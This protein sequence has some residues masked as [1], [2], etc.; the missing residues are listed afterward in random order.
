MQPRMTELTAVD[1]FCGGGGL[2]VGLKQAGFRVVSAVE[3]EAH[4]FST[5]KANHPDVHAYKQDIRTIRGKDLKKHS[6]SGKIDLLA[7]C[8][9]CQGFSS[10]TAKYRRNDPRNALVREMARLV[11]ELK[12][13][14][15]MM[16]NVP[17]L[18]QKG[19]KFFNE[20]LS[21]LD[22][23]GY[24]YNF[25]VLQ[26]ADYGVPQS[27]RRLVLLAGRGFEVQLPTPSH[28]RVPEG[29]LRPWKTVG[30]AIRG[31]REPVRLEE[32]VLNGG[33]QQYNWHVVRTLSDKNLSR[34]RKAKPGSSWLKIPSR[35]RPACHQGIE[36]GFG[37]VYGRMQWDAVSPTITGGCT[38]LSKGRFGHPSKNR[39]ISLREAALLQTFPSNY[40]FD[41][42]YM[43]YAC[44]I[45]G[46]ALPCEFARKVSLACMKSIRG[47]QGKRLGG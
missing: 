39:T 9:P 41:T 34:L 23:L 8:P 42:P 37:N 4:A 33:V 26:V 18:T 22:S 36:L 13:T 28:A 40:I 43:E 17:G 10:L 35:L 31:M 15:V 6:P 29:R 24:Q 30:K 32:A 16:E 19:R 46:N 45:V 11:R 3:M 20:F 25:D 44:D 27:R 21:T 2:T 1:L 47:N 38:T 12:P 14:V 7:G 5:Y